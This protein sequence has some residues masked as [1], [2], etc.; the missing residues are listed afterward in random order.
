MN[1]TATKGAQTDNGR[2]GE[3]LGNAPVLSLMLKFAIPSIVGMLVSALYNMVD[4]LF[5]GKAVSG[6]V[7]VCWLSLVVVVFF[8]V[9]VVV[10]AV[11]EVVVGS[12]VIDVSC[13]ERLCS[14]SCCV[15]F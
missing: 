7:I 8:V 6:V 1:K 4:Q 14:S 5:I 12:I 9:D 10:V 3:V 2:N 11:A 13:K 15:V